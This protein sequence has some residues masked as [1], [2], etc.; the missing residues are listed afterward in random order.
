[1]YSTA[2]LV[3]LGGAFGAMV[4]EFIMLLIPSLHNGFPLDILVANVIAAF[5]LGLATAHHRLQN[6]SDDVILLFGTG[7]LGGMSTF[8]SFAYGAAHESLQPGGLVLS[9]LYM[10]LSL[11]LGFIAVWL[12]LTLANRMSVPPETKH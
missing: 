12:G 4:R 1:M 5:L 3:F 10:L 9:L 8:S 7:A 11:V 6:L 2:I